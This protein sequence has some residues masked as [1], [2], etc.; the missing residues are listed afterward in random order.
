MKALAVDPR[1][2]TN[3][4]YK[5]FCLMDGNWRLYSNKHTDLMRQLIMQHERQCDWISTISLTFSQVNL[6]QPATNND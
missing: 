1:Q 5:Q 2:R 3:R 6:T 4:S